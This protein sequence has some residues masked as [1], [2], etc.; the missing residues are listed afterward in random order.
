MFDRV[1]GEIV[2]REPIEYHGDP[3]R[4]RI[5][6]YTRF[7]IDLSNPSAPLDSTPESNCRGRRGKMLRYLPQ[8]HFRRAKVE[9][10]R[11]RRNLVPKRSAQQE[12]IE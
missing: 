2:L 12:R 8:F 9:P 1:G 4:G 5:A 6:C 10:L 11:R 3:L 7:G